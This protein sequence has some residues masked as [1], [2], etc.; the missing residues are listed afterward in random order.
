MMS[1]THSKWKIVPATLLTMAVAGCE[2]REPSPPPT[3]LPSPPVIEKKI[4]LATA[5]RKP[6]LLD[7]LPFTVDVPEGWKIVRYGDRPTASITMLEGPLPSGH[8][9]HIILSS[10]EPISADRLK[11]IL[12][13][14]EKD[15]PRIEA[16]GGSLTVRDIGEA[17]AVE[18]REITSA[19]APTATAPSTHPATLPADAVVD[20]RIHLFV[21]SGLRY[22]QYE[23]NLLDV[24]AEQFLQD[25]AFLAS[26]L[27]SLRY[28]EVPP[29]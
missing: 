5:P 24:Q 20:W 28:A 26:I 10:R 29:L 12:N 6:L 7:L 21:P 17:R 15:R 13:Q 22:N 16:A 25:E 3:A 19:S 2:K 18:R 1:G 27:G 11:A 9:C 23:L 4:D 14:F 8:T